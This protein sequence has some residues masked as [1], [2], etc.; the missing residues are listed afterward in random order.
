MPRNLRRFSDTLT[1][2]FTNTKTYTKKALYFFLYGH[3]FIWDYFQKSVFTMG[4]LAV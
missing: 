1:Y 3:L 4:N 2:I